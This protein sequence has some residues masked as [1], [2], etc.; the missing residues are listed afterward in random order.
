MVNVVDYLVAQGP[1]F[2]ASTIA[3]PRNLRQMIERN[4]ERLTLDEQSVLEAASVAGAEFSAAA[5][6]ALGAHSAGDRGVLHETGAARTVRRNARSQ[7]SGLTARSRAASASIMRCI[8]RR[9]MDAC[10]RAIASSCIDALRRAKK[11]RLVN[12][13][14]KSRRNWR[15]TTATVT[16]ITRRSNIW[17]R[18]RSRGRPT[19]LSRGRA[20][21]SQRDRLYCR[22]CLNRPSAIN[23]N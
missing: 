10:R 21:L 11:L 1:E 15:I 8:R 22:P 13:Q 4:L 14:E 9:S 6:A 12:A 2:D 18:W 7:S 20:T 3:A 5:V 17:T 16:T 19:R 23:T